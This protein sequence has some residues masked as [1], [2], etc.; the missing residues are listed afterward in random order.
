MKW[1]ND[2]GSEILVW[3]SLS[4]YEDKGCAGKRRNFKGFQ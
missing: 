1:N 4:S 2:D 3:F